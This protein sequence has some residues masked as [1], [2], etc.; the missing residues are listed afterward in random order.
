SLGYDCWLTVAS[1]GVMEI[2]GGVNLLGFL[3][4]SGTVNWQGGDISVYCYG[5]WW[6]FHGEIWNQAQAVWNIQCDQTL[7]GYGALAPFFNAGLIKKTAGTNATTLDVY[8]ANSGEVHEESGI[9]WLRQGG[10]LGG[11][12]EADAGAAIYF[13]SG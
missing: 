1:N 6:D 12:F 8:L 13:T 2:L 3:T 10:A 4:N 5:P 11:T 9:M 7:V